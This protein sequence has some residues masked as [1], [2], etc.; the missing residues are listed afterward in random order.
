MNR[1]MSWSPDPAEVRKSQIVRWMNQLGKAFDF[2]D[3]APG[4][5]DF[6][7]WS[8][9][10]PGDFWHELMSDL[11]VVW[12]TPYEEVFD[13]SAG[14]EW[15]DWFV[16]GR[17]NLVL[18]CVDMP[19]AEF[20][21]RL[22]LVGEE[23]D[24]SVR[25]W[26]FA[27]VADEVDQLAALM[28]SRG[29]APGDR[30]GCL[31]PMVAEVSFAMLA[32][33]KIGAVFIPI[34][35]GY[36]APSVR[37]RLEDS[38]AKW[39]FTADIGYRRGSSFDLKSHADKAIEGLECVETLLVL[40]RGN[41]DLPM[42]E[43]RDLWW[44]EASKLDAGDRSTEMMGAMDPALMIYTSGTT[45][46]PKGTVHT[47]AGC[48]AQMGKELRFNFDVGRED[49]LFW[50]FTDIGWMM[51]PW[52]IIGCWL[53]RTPFLVCEG[54]PDY[55][56]PGRLWEMVERHRVSHLGISPTAIRLLMR[57]G[58]EPFEGKD[59]SSLRILGSTGEPWDPESYR[60]FHENLGGGKLPIINISGGTDI[61]GCFLA[62]LPVLPIS[63][64]SLQSPG[65]GMDIDVFNEAGESVSE[66]VGFL[67][68]KSPAPSMTRS[69]W[70]ADE[71]YIET[72]W[73][74]FPGIWNH[75]DWARKD[76]DGQ[77]YLFGRADD[78]LNIAGRRVGPGEVESA[79]I[80][81]D[82]VSE[83][84]AIG[85]PD[86]LKGTELVCFV[87]LHPGYEESEELRDQLKG[88]VVEALG[89]VDRPRSIHYVDDL[90]KT[91]SAKIVRRLIRARH[92]GDEDLG[93]LTSIANP[94][95]LEGISRCR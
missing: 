7:Q 30:V 59:L 82:A 61:V 51:G 35:S 48:M 89:K 66:E 29:I 58:I 46:K 12:S 8:Q 22:A 40:Q 60:W 27:E 80:E 9:K 77:W 26:T 49:D 1:P 31:M 13:D 14:P 44:S 67:V 25:R 68:C 85:V 86:E 65:L 93:D 63:E 57:S 78:T 17:T 11:G 41:D 81:H 71:K 15:T 34:F 64:T 76:D 37:E 36:A 56:G 53:N 23:E 3:P 16:G 24:G 69:L 33:M 94:E 18:N 5:Q 90:P 45:G 87:V 73:S 21:E 32:T 42:K 43:G 19:A 52:E 47:H 70:K 84:A 72:Y 83:A 28:R 92:L 6:I 55:P 75:G 2:E 38:G 91:R 74:R 79:L 54:A 50:W 20:P 62:P 10:H 39:L 4:I 95:A 88:Q